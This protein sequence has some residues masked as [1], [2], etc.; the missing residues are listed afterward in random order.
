MWVHFELGCLGLD[1]GAGY[2]RMSMGLCEI[3]FE[4]DESMELHLSPLGLYGR[5]VVRTSSKEVL[6]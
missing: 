4:I 6:L 1:S 5:Q 3:V 2:A